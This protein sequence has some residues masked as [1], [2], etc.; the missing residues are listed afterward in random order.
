MLDKRPYVGRRKEI[1]EQVMVKQA[2]I[3]PEEV[4]RG[5]SMEAA[6]FANKVRA[7]LIQLMIRNP[8]LRLGAKGDEEVRKH[9]W[10]KS[11]DWGRLIRKEIPA[12]YIPTVNSLLF[13]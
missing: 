2:V 5:W 13:R 9:P 3:K 11:V 6:D 8:D 1:A 7:L 12:P 4:P 10:L